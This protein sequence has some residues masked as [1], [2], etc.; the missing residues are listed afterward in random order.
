MNMHNQFEF[1]PIIHTHY[2]CW[3]SGNGIKSRHTGS[4]P[5]PVIQHKHFIHVRNHCVTH[6]MTI[7]HDFPNCYEFRS[8]TFRLFETTMTYCIME[9]HSQRAWSAVIWTYTYSSYIDGAHHS[10][11]Q[12]TLRCNMTSLLYV[13]TA[14]IYIRFSLLI[15]SNKQRHVVLHPLAYFLY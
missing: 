9:S 6:N 5:H 3:W 7:T 12:P 10:F 13:H 14:Y 4:S 2:M 1:Y 15:L 8:S 11:T